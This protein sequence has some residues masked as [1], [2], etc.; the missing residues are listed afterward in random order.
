MNLDGFRF[1]REACINLACAA[2]F[3]AWLASMLN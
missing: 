1:P 3:L 2:I